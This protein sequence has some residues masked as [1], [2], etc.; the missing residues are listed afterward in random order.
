MATIDGFDFSKFEDQV[1]ELSLWLQK[2]IAIELG[3]SHFTF[4]IEIGRDGNQGPIRIIYGLGEFAAS[5]RGGSIF[6]VLNEMLRRC[7]WNSQHKP[8]EIP[9]DGGK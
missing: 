6:H 2:Q 4:S 3:V 7:H 9:I 1:I 8:L 5:T